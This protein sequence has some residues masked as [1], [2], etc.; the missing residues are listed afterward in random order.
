MHIEGVLLDMREEN[1]LGDS[2]VDVQ[3]KSSSQNSDTISIGQIY[4][5]GLAKAKLSLIVITLFNI[6]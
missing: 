2:Q 5:E 6:S 4:S 1:V 3:R